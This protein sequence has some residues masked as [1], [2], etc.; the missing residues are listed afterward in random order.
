MTLNELIIN[1][2]KPLEKNDYEFL[3]G[4]DGLAHLVIVVTV[5]R[6]NGGNLTYTFFNPCGALEGHVGD[7]EVATSITCIAC[8]AA[9]LG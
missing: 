1:R 4:G 7:R 5:T 9:S 6:G 8:N 3:L 2:G